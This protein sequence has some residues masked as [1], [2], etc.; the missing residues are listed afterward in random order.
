MFTNPQRPFDPEVTV[1]PDTK[2][3]RKQDDISALFSS[4]FCA[5]LLSVSLESLERVHF[6]LGQR[7]QKKRRT[8]ERSAQK[9]AF[10]FKELLALC[11]IFQLLD[12]YKTILPRETQMHAN[13]PH[14]ISNF[15]PISSCPYMLCLYPSHCLS[16]C[17]FFDYLLSL[18]S[19]R[20]PVYHPTQ[21]YKS[22]FLPSFLITIPMA[23]YN[24]PSYTYYF[25]HFLYLS[26]HLHLPMIFH[27]LTTLPILPLP[28]TSTY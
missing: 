7:K 23:L 18:C 13:S 12:I 24:F 3:T 21:I 8:S 22:I 14:G 27:L 11:K 10:S 9:I 19:L 20:K 26:L 6:I 25:S 16:V 2:C 4:R 28:L 1:W 17:L 5:Q 15:I